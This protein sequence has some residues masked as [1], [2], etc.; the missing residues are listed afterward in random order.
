[1]AQNK[2]RCVLVMRFSALGDVMMVLPVLYDTCRAHPDVR[3][4]L[5]SRPWAV[6][7]AQCPP[8]N[9][10]VVPVDLKGAHKGVAG[11]LRLAGELKRDH[12][13]DV[14]ADLHSV[15]RTWALGAA[16]W[17]RGV[18]VRRIDKGR[19]DKR[20]LIA[21]QTRQPLQH[22]TERYRRVFARLGLDSQPAFTTLFEHGLPPCTL[23][24]DKPAGAR[25]LAVAPFAAHEGK[26][27][28][29]E[30]MRQVVDRLA[31]DPQ[32][33][34]FLLGGG[35]REKAALA[36]WEEAHDN[37][38]SVAA[39]DHTFADELALVARCDAM[40]SM[41][42]ANMHLASLVDVPVVSVWGATHPDCGFMG[43]RQSTDHAVQLELDCRPCSVFGNKPCR[44]GDRRCMT[45]ITPE[46]IV[47]KVNQLTCH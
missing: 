46:M 7:L 19:R 36:P 21:G 31:A 10:T 35:D 17:L 41:D 30:R 44:L 43:Y 13:I 45:G 5:A 24:G 28:P 9:L 4:V 37:V 18:A 34:I 14:L 47:N 40:V 27:Y 20:A 26:V 12:H 23:A 2:P 15:M 8:P 29:L 6:S 33:R 1:M 3:F 16:L 22:T 39:I 42:S 32:T 25:W 38:T 11:M